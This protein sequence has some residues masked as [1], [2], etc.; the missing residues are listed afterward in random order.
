MPRC[1]G[2][3]L[4]YYRSFKSSRGELYTT[5]HEATSASVITYIHAYHFEE[6]GITRYDII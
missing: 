2:L 4:P 1:L 6:A 3:A 5:N